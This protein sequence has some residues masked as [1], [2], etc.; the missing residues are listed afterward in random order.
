MYYIWFRSIFWLGMMSNILSTTK[1]LINKIFLYT[2]I[3]IKKPYGLRRLKIL[4][5][6]KF[7]ELVLSEI[8]FH[9]ANIR[10]NPLIE[11]FYFLK[12]HNIFQ[13]FSSIKLSIGECFGTVTEVTGRELTTRLFRVLTLEEKCE[14]VKLSVE[15]YKKISKV[16]ANKN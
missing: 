15:S 1:Y 3:I 9:F 16:K 6:L 8:L 2:I 7:H 13:V 11:V 14:F 4:F 12:D 10:L 5:D